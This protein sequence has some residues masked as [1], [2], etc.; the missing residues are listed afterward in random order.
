MLHTPFH[1]QNYRFSGGAMK[2]SLKAIL[3]AVLLSAVPLALA[4][5]VGSDV[6]KTTKDTG[7]D[8]KKAATKTGHATEKAADK[9][10]DATKTAAVK[11]GPETKVV[12]KDRGKGPETV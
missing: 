3:A 4:Q 6:K 2:V 1:S 10:G 7:T 5:D 9:T 11:T 8:T 12:A